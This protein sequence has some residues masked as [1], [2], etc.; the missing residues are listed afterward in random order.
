MEYEDLLNEGKGMNLDNKSTCNQMRR[1]N[2]EYHHSCG[3]LCCNKDM[4]DGYQSLNVH[5]QPIKY[6]IE[7]TLKYT[8]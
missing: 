7:Y 5:K 8:G 1:N 4:Q 3:S 2:M 6:T